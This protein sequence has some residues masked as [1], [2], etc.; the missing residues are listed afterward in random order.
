MNSVKILE[1]AMNSFIQDQST[2]V[3]KLNEMVG[4]WGQGGSAAGAVPSRVSKMIQK[5]E[6]VS[7]TPSQKRRKSVNDNGEEIIVPV[8]VIH[9]TD[10]DDDKVEKEVTKDSWAEVTGKKVNTP[11]KDHQRRGQ[12]KKNLTIVN[13]SDKDGENGASGDFAA[14][15]SLVAYGVAKDASAE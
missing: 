14:D 11:R 13:G 7:T 2:Q 10:G 4:S 12:W 5:L 6:T 9:V 3:R 8:P 15:V 1:Q